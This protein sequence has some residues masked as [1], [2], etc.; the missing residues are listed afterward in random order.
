M[1]SNCC[2]IFLSSAIAAGNNKDGVPTRDIKGASGKYLVY[3]S[4]NGE[5]VLSCI[6]KVATN[7][8]G[9]VENQGLSGKLM[10]EKMEGKVPMKAGPGNFCGL[11]GGGA[12]F[13]IE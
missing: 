4:S 10:K 8:N 9:C 5:I 6:W 3:G 2:I 11:V 7:V 13:G 1:N 12:K